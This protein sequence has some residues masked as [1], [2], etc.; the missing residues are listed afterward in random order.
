MSGG[1]L[2]PFG[3]LLLARN[4][5]TDEAVQRPQLNGQLSAECSVEIQRGYLSTFLAQQFR[6]G[7]TDAGSSASDHYN[8][9]LK[10]FRHIRKVGTT[11]V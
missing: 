6:C 7:F 9:I 2:N 3:S 11:I 5:T 8:L 4:I 1:K 10:A